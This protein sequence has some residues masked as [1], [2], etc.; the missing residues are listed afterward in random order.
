M[1]HKIS[2]FWLVMAILAI[3]FPIVLAHFFP[4]KCYPGDWLGFFGGYSGA[5]IAIGGV[6]WQVSKQ[7][8]RYNDSARPKFG[9]TY[10][11]ALSANDTVY[12]NSNMS[13]WYTSGPEKTLTSSSLHVNLDSDGNEMGGLDFNN[14]LRYQSPLLGIKNISKHDAYTCLLELKYFSGHC[15]DLCLERGLTINKSLLTRL[16]DENHTETLTI[17]VISQ[18]EQIIILPTPAAFRKRYLLMSV[19]MVYE[20]ETTEINDLSFQVEQDGNINPNKIPQYHYEHSCLD[21]KHKRDTFNPSTFTVVKSSK[22]D[23]HTL[24]S[25][26]YMSPKK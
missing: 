1:R 12:T 21:F 5:L 7:S 14:K 4:I 15:T 11:R 9:I 24:E 25:I 10:L 20:T 23:I 18:K 8:R 19:S 6:Y 17:P 26:N 13:D 2:L 22:D 16:K 3:G